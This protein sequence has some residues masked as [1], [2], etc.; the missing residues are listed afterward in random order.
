MS[1][2]VG[3]TF[4]R[5]SRVSL[6]LTSSRRGAGTIFRG[7]GFTLKHAPSDSNSLLHAITRSLGLIPRAQWTTVTLARWVR[8]LRSHLARFADSRA[9]MDSLLSDSPFDIDQALFLTRLWDIQTLLYRCNE[10]QGSISVHP[11][12]SHPLEN[13][14]FLRAVVHIV[15]WSD[16]GFFDYV[17]PST[18]HHAPHVCAIE[19]SD[20]S[21]FE[22][23]PQA[24]ELFD[25]F[26]D[27]WLDLLFRQ[28]PTKL[29]IANYS[30]TSIASFREQYP[31][32]SWFAENFRFQ[33]PTNTCDA[34]SEEFFVSPA[35]VA[36]S[37][38]RSGV[39]VASRESGSLGYPSS[40][41]V[42]VVIIILSYVACCIFFLLLHCFCLIFPSESGSIAPSELGARLRSHAAL[43]FNFV[44]DC[45]V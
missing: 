31:V 6:S 9:S 27:I 42:L 35:F 11:P 36:E 26:M 22:G 44:N 5:S 28:P 18:I 33:V 14:G 16:L 40:R 12:V 45:V 41:C 32:A 17:E 39:S 25:R 7:Y 43:I 3:T 21:F 34:S 13:P 8:I 10:S 23:S 30:W 20:L 4:A 38:L 24:A 2:P 37:D 15:D 29:N 19:A 1:A